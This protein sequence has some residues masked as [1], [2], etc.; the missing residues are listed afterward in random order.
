MILLMSVMILTVSKAC[1]KSI[2]TSVV[3]CGGLFLLKP[4]MIGSIIECS[5][6]VVECLGLKPC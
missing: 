3:L 6:V 4:L 1:E 5:A 2:A